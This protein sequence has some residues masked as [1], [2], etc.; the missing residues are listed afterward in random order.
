MKVLN[1]SAAVAAP[2]FGK[3]G[4]LKSP[5]NKGDGPQAR[6]IVFKKKKPAS[7]KVLFADF[8]CIKIYDSHRYPQVTL[9]LLFVMLFLIC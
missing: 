2:S 3:G 7:S 8:L 9:V 4:K 1:P 5:F 6:G